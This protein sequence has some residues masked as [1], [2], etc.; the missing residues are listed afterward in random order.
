LE[1]APL[2]QAAGE[3]RRELRL[4]SRQPL[5]HANLGAAV[6][7]DFELVHELGNEIKTTTTGALRLR[8]AA[9]IAAT[10]VHAATAV[11]DQY[12][13]VLLIDGEPH[14]DVVACG[15]GAALVDTEAEVVSCIAVDAVLEQKCPH[16]ADVSGE[17]RGIGGHAQA[18]RPGGHA[19]HLLLLAG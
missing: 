6:N 10:E 13:D 4:R 18:Q 14:V 1:G 5:R 17:S 7:T 12:G 3:P 19:Y 11:A 9:R 15:V 16:A 8:R 2:S